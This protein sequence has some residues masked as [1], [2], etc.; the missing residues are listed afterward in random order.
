MSPRTASKNGAPTAKKARTTSAWEELTYQPGFG[1]HFCSET[2]PGALPKG[3][4]NPQKC[5][6]GLYAEQLSGT[7]FTLPR[8]KNQRSWLY[9]ILPPVVHEKYKEMEHQFLQNDFSQ[10]TLTP[11]QMR[12]SPMPFPDE[13]E[14]LDFVTG[15]KTVGGAG[16]PTLKDGLA[17]HN[18]GA[19]VSM[20]NKCFYNSDGDF[21]I[22]TSCCLVV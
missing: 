17:I 4:N 21:L 3:Q 13:G 2:L 14:E 11:Q 5:P 12:W 6:Y 22:G 19:N 9:R 15:I 1:G 10:A 18:Y 16:D 7:A 20:T 8:D